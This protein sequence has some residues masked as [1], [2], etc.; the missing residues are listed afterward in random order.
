[1]R[2]RPRPATKSGHGVGN[3][4]DSQPDPRPSVP[5]NLN[6]YVP[7]AFARANARLRFALQQFTGNGLQSATAES[8]ALKRKL[9]AGVLG[10][11]GGQKLLADSQDDQSQPPLAPLFSGC[12]VAAL[13]V[14]SLLFRR[15][16]SHNQRGLID[17]YDG[18]SVGFTKP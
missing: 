15:L 17:L 13:C 18:T 6:S 4:K 8:P 9:T 7:E 3:S 10:F 16:Y 5:A 14:G 2:L 12:S 1:M 11:A